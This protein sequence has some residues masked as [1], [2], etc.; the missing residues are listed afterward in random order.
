MAAA[1]P[2]PPTLNKPWKPDIS[3]R[4]SRRSTSTAWAFMATS[5]A[6]SI[7][8]KYSSAAT[9]TITL[10]AK[11]STGSARHSSHP[12]ATIT[13]RLPRRWLSQ[14]TNGIDKVSL[15]GGEN[16][17][18][19]LATE[20]ELNASFEEVVWGG[21]DEVYAI[22]LGPEPGLN[23]TKLVAIDPTK[24]GPTKFR[25]LA[26]APWFTDQENGAAFV[27]GGLALTKEHVV[28]GDH[29]PGKPRIRVFSR[30]TGA[31]VAAIPTTVGAPWSL[32]A[33]P[34]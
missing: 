22:T 2:R 7:T 11:A 14:P 15:V 30:A 29:T 1:P 10:G 27:H 23:P 25:V 34:P 5:T 20:L 21:D 24:S 18:T 6:P 26:R 17:L 33:L 32:V 16:A 19:Q 12:D 31:E 8:P 4:P 9:N 28:V 13:R 3:A